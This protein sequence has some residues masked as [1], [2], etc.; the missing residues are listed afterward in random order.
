LSYALGKPFKLIEVKA[1]TGLIGVWIN[2]FLRHKD[3]LSADFIFAAFQKI[4]PPVRIC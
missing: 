3:Y 4:N 1:L 2:L